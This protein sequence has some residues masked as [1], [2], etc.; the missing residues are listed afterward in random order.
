MEKAEGH[1][2]RS[3]A[4]LF[5]NP[6]AKYFNFVAF[7]K[8]VWIWNVPSF[9]DQEIEIMTLCGHKKK[10]TETLKEREIDVPAFISRFP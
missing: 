9:P 10:K 1:F 4:Q 6:S 3:E 5:K 7:V 2:W 8:N